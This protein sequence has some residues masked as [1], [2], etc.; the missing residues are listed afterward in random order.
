MLD[1]CFRIE[2]LKD[3]DDVPRFLGEDQFYNVNI[4]NRYEGTYEE[5]STRIITK[6]NELV[7]EYFDKGYHNPTREEQ[8]TGLYVDIRE[9]EDKL[10]DRDW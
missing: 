1:T 9:F 7:F 5:C 6:V 2:K 10:K 3:L 8:Q 4:T